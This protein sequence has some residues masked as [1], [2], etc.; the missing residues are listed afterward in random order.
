MGGDKWYHTG[1]ERGTEMEIM[2]VHRGD[3]MS[4]L[5]WKVMR[6]LGWEVTGALRWNVEGLKWEVWSLTWK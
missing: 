6:S 2:G 3:M 5:K 4:G 1:G